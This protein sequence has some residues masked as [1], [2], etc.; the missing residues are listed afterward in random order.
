MIKGR[1]LVPQD[2]QFKA[3]LKR[4]FC[5]SRRVECFLID[6]LKASDLDQLF[7]LGLSFLRISDVNIYKRISFCH[8]SATLSTNACISVSRETIRSKKKSDYNLN[9]AN[10]L[11]LTNTTLNVI[12]LVGESC[13]LTHAQLFHL[14]F[15]ESTRHQ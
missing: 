2:H 4:S 8:D 12:R 11:I 13:S 10:T 9:K 3:S 7:E 5:T 15:P 14:P 1:G 6:Q